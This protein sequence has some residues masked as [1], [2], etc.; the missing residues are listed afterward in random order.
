[1]RERTLKFRA[2][3]K[4]HKIMHTKVNLYSLNRE[5]IMDRAQ[6]DNKQIMEN[7]GGS[8]EVMQFVG[9]HDRNG[10]EIFE[11]DI[12]KIHGLKDYYI[13]IY[14]EEF[15]EFRMKHYLSESG[16]AFH[17]CTKPFEVVGNLFETPHLLN[18]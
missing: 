1:M 3:S 13:V 12:I 5:G 6:L 17:V 10:K 11:A 15:C 16:Y 7:I 2:W 4:G 8:C 14:D 18:P 9:R